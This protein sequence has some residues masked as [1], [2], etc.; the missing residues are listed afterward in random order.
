M[1]ANRTPRAGFTLIELLMVIVIIA[2][3]MGLASFAAFQAIVKAR[4]AK[5]TMEIGQLD[6]AMQGYKERYFE[7][8][9]SMTEKEEKVRQTRLIEHLR[10][11]FPRY[12]VPAYATLQKGIRQGF[13]KNSPGY[14]YRSAGGTI[15]ELDL[16]TL[17]P[18]E[19]LVF[20]LG[21]FP[22]P[23]D[24][25]TTAAIAGR[26]M[27]G[28]HLDPKAP[29]K[30]DPRI[31]EAPRPLEFRTTPLFEFDETRLVDHDD[32]GWLEYIPPGAV[33]G[34]LGKMPPYVYFDFESYVT[35][36]S[37][38]TI[39]HW[40]FPQSPAF[41]T[42]W[43]VAVPYALYFDQ[44]GDSPTRWQNAGKFQIISAGVDARYSSAPSGQTTMRVPIFPNPEFP[45]GAVFRE[46]ASYGK[47]EYYDESELDN[48]TNFSEGTI[49]DS[50]Q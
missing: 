12:A 15:E 29:L 33:S 34:G 40:G 8:P 11:A 14:N 21:G 4:K 27:F 1:F 42:E 13:D 47:Q 44:N 39:K 9:P 22:T 16:E 46:S 31:N 3:L 36:G 6:Q 49:E 24:S 41:N 18:G 26:R 10:A 43:G 28:F 37:A 38:E 23:W 45:N 19:A 30:R 50:V 25:Q 20:W 35:T 5:I 48:L 32:D 17:D 7:Y 2:M